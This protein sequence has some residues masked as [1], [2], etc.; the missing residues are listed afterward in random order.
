[1]VALRARALK[2]VALS[3]PHLS[4]S[5]ARGLV[6][7]ARRSPKAVRTRRSRSFVFPI[8]VGL[9]VLVAS[10]SDPRSSPQRRFFSL[11]VGVA[12]RHTHARGCAQAGALCSRRMRH[13]QPWRHERAS[14]RGGL[15]FC[16]GGSAGTTTP[17]SLR[18]F[19]SSLV[20]PHNT[21]EPRV[22]HPHG[23]GWS[24]VF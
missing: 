4:I 9:M 14:E 16:V 15:F 6:K 3:R 11:D 5:R 19:L 7:V 22:R 23:G 21:H 1:M 13:W 18:V 2:Q 10:Y 17:S 20:V 24:S 8:L 12:A